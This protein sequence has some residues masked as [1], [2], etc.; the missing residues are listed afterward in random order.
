MKEKF[1]Q[2]WMDVAKYILTGVVLASV[3]SDIE[4]KAYIYTLGCVLVVLFL[5]IG[6]YLVKDETKK[7]NNKKG[8]K[9]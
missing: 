9:K 6:L 4:D 1:G 7:K 2:W 8:K 3:F 5:S